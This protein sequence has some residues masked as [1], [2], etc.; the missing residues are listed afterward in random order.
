M[1]F[2]NKY[3]LVE[4]IEVKQEEIDEYVKENNMIYYNCSAKS[5]INVH[6]G[7]SALAH[8]IKQNSENNKL[9]GI[10][11]N[12]L[13]DVNTKDTIKLNNRICAEG[14]STCPTCTIV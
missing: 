9:I 1:L 2:G 10:E 5:D 6:E 7:F 13:Y 4:K 14:D 3:D 12:L 11:K 8:K